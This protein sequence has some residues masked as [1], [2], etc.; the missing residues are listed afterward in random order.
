MGVRDLRAAAAERFRKAAWDIREQARDE[1][2][3]IILERT[4]TTREAWAF[5]WAE[6]A[7]D[8]LLGLAEWLEP[9]DDPDDEAEREAA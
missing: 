9:E 1:E 5:V 6:Y 7:T 2:A 8:Y 3:G 4:P